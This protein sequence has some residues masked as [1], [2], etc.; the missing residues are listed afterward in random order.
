MQPGFN[1]DDIESVHIHRAKRV[2]PL[3]VLNYSSLVPKVT[4]EHPDFYVLNTSQF[5]NNTLNNNEVIRFVEHFLQ[6]HAAEFNQ[7][8]EHKEN[9]A[10]PPKRAADAVLTR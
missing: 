2:Q 9:T 3:Q 10:V 6:E 1:P 8:S 4:T 7:S 5:V